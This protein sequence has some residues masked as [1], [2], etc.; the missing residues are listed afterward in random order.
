MKN[1]WMLLWVT[2][3]LFTGCD[4]RYTGDV[5][6]VLPGP[7]GEQEENPYKTGV[8]TSSPVSVEWKNADLQDYLFLGY[9]YDMTGR[10]AHPSSVRRKVFD[11]WAYEEDID[12]ILQWVKTTSSSANA[13]YSGTPEECRWRL[14]DCAGFTEDEIGRYRN[15]FKDNLIH[16]FAN[17]DSFAELQYTYSGYS[18]MGQWYR[19]SF[20]WMEWA[21]MEKYLTEEFRADLEHLPAGEIIKIYGTHMITGL[22]AGT[23]IDRIYRST[24]TDKYEVYD[25]MLYNSRRFLDPDEPLPA[26]ES[27]PPLKDNIYFEYIDS[28]GRQPNAWMIDILH[29][30]KEPIRFTETDEYPEEYSTMIDFSGKPLPIYLLVTDPG[31]R[32]E[33]E[34]AFN[35]Y[36]GASTDG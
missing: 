15:L 32:A 16:A 31:K 26:P 4:G 34:A 20:L 12:G 3:L 18:F 35:S 6:P 29:Y 5:I 17:D 25:W 14:A 10:Y 9:G 27:D 8:D 23:R 11:I 2:G 21:F 24:S 33:L 30:E 36:L 28:S 1:F 22:K 19:M 7:G 13:I